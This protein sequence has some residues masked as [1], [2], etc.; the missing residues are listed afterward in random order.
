[1]NYITKNTQLGTLFVFESGLKL[2]LAGEHGRGTLEQEGIG[3][4]VRHAGD[5]FHAIRI[6]ETTCAADVPARCKAW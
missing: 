4:P 1:M 5:V 2:T 3:Y 6:G